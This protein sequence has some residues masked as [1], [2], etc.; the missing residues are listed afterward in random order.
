VVETVEVAIASPTA[1][2]LPPK[3]PAPDLFSPTPSEPS[4]LRVNNNELS[5]SGSQKVSHIK[6]ANLEGMTRPSRRARAAVSYAEPSLN[7]KMRRPDKALVSAVYVRPTSNPPAS[8]TKP[9]ARTVIIKKEK[10]EDSEASWKDLPSVLPAEPTSPSE[11]KAA[12]L[13]PKKPVLTE[14]DTSSG[15][16]AGAG[17]AISALMSTD[18]GG[19]KASH[20]ERAYDDRRLSDKMRELDLYDFKESSPAKQ[21]VDVKAQ[22]RQRRHSSVA[23]NLTTGSKDVTALNAERINSSSPLSEEVAAGTGAHARPSSLAVKTAAPAQGRSERTARRR[24]MM[25]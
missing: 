16:G 17:A 24:S 14:S 23:S 15:I 20:N 8:E 2:A 25:V 13:G 6:D 4:T 3:T 19:V 18:A 5:A 22:A 10:E 21:E 12:S 11:A 9:A 7:T 1:Q